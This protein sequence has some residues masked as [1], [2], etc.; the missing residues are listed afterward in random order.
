MVNLKHVHRG[1]VG[2]PLT[3]YLFCTLHPTI[4]TIIFLSQYTSGDSYSTTGFNG[5][6]GLEPSMSNPLGN[7]SYPGYTSSNGPNWVDYLT[8]VFN[9]SLLETYNFAYGGATLDSDLVQPYL[10]SVR[11]VKQQVQDEFLPTYG[12][13][14]F[15]PWMSNNTLFAFFVGINDVGNSYCQPNESDIQTRI[16]QEYARL[17]DSVYAAGGRK[18]LFLNVPPIQ[19]APQ[20]SIH[21]AIVQKQEQRAIIDWNSRLAELAVGMV[22]DYPDVTTL[23]FDTYALFST[24]LR[25]PTFFPQTAQYKNTT[26]YCAEY[27]NGTPTETYLDPTCGIPVNEYFWL[28]TLH[29]TYPMHKVVAQQIALILN[30][31]VAAGCSL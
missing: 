29:P 12:S 21:G 28:N 18:F 5:T 6:T 19:F 8:T 25:D 11:S 17:V 26:G 3:I 2:Q 4:R 22:N 30:N 7:P 15:T 9:E 31:P 27:M 14:P 1:Q 23:T 16:F 20:T 24:V 10:P 13:S